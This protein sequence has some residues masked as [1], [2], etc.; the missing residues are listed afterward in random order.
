M[1]TSRL[2]ASIVLNLPVVLGLPIVGICRGLHLAVAV[3]GL[4]LIRSGLL[5]ITYKGTRDV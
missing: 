5:G 1:L 4:A 3:G 2:G